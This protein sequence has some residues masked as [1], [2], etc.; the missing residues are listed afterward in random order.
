MLLSVMKFVVIFDVL[1]VV[2]IYDVYFDL[3]TVISPIQK[4][5]FDAVLCCDVTAMWMCVSS[6]PLPYI[7][8]LAETNPQ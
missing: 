1:F 3:P 7:S 5:L 2:E 8:R 4:E 6:M